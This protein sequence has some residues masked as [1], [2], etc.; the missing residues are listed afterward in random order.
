MKTLLTILSLFWASFSFAETVT[1]TTYDSGFLKLELPGGAFNVREGAIVGVSMHEYILD[2]AARVTEMNI[3]T[4]PS[5]TQVRFYHIDPKLASSPVGLGQSVLDKMQEKAKE[6][7]GRVDQLDVLNKVQK[8]YP[9]TTHAHTIEYRFVQKEALLEFYDKVEKFFLRKLAVT[10]STTSGT[11]T[12]ATQTT[13]ATV[14]TGRLIK[15][16]N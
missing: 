5:Q 13:S 12:S 16:E 4:S 9:N 3:L 2:S 8:H 11:S 10:Q 14:G 6:G 1:V 7:L 15:V